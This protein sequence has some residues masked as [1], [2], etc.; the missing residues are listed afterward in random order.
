MVQFKDKI[1]NQPLRAQQW[2]LAQDCWEEPG[3]DLAL[4][5]GLV[6]WTL[7]AVFYEK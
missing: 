5:L 7:E 1:F 4:R 3:E 2:A 6:R